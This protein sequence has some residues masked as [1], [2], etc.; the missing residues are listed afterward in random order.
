VGTSTWD[1]IYARRLARSHLDAP[2]PLGQAV[3][4]TRDVLGLHAQLTTGAILALSARVAGVTRSVVHELLWERRALVKGNT[5]R[6]TLHLHPPDDYVLWKSAYEPR[7]RTARWLE[8]QGLTLAEAEGLRD[9]VLAVLD[10]PRT[11]V[12]I[13]AA[14]GG[15][16]GRR[17]AEDSWGHLLSPAGD[18]CCQGPPRG[19]EVT[20]VRTDVW[21]PGSAR[22]DRVDALRELV[23]RYVSTY[24]PVERPDLEHWLAAK[25]PQE[26]EVPDAGEPADAEPRGVRL[27]SHYDVYVIACHP[28]AHLIPEQKERVFLR[29]GGPNPTLLVDGR[30]AG[31][32]RRDGKRIDVEPFRALTKPQLAELETE[33]ARVLA[34]LS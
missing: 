5:I 21:I 9:A 8:W 17:I 28:R 6:G 10:E 20:F 22:V 15:V 34:A 31:V 33:R 7:W 12:E 27:L 23:R 25:L 3:D 4:V 30:V 1:R 16:L 19:R 18:E 32:W 11:R 13:G 14:V 29:G 26:V 24:G 2:A